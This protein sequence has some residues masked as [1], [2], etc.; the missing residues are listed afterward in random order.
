MD[1]EPALAQNRAER[2]DWSADLFVWGIWLGLTLVLLAFI[3]HFASN[4]PLWDD[5]KLVPVLTGNSPLD[6]SW[7]WIQCN[8][9][10][11]SLVR[12][13]WLGRL[14]SPGDFLDQA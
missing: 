5:F 13:I 12:L 6:A 11:M 14:A 2:S 4:L 7:L 9:P 3:R 10:R 8:E 1:A